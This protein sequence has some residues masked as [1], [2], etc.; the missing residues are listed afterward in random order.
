MGVGFALEPPALVLTD[1]KEYVARLRLA[2]R[3]RK[4]LRS[5]SVDFPVEVGGKKSSG[6]ASYV[7]PV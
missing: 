7:N 5:E 2:C 1:S 4:M 3:I 6:P